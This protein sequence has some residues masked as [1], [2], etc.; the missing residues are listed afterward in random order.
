MIF[1]SVQ[2]IQYLDGIQ[3]PDVPV[4]EDSLPYTKKYKV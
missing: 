2:Y 1:C 4:L 3:Y